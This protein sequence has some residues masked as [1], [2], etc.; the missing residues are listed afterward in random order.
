M[1]MVCMAPTHDEAV[2]ASLEGLHYFRNALRRQPDGSVPNLA[3]AEVT[4][5]MIRHG[6]L[7]GFAPPV[8]GTPDEAYELLAPLMTMPGVTHLPLSFRHAG[9]GPRSPAVDGP[10]PPR[11]CFRPCGRSK[12]QGIPAA[13]M[14][15]YTDSEGHAARTAATARSLPILPACFY[16][17]HE[18]SA[19]RSTFVTAPGYIQHN[20]GIPDGRGA[21]ATM[22]PGPD[23]LRSRFPRR[24]QAAARW[25]IQ[26]SSSCARLPR[27]RPRGGAVMERWPTERSSNTRTSSSRSPE[28][29]CN[30]HPLLL[31]GRC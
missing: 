24:P 27:G 10:V 18:T 28:T 31:S 14:I 22:G 30:D 13:A 26:A 1:Q 6:D 12:K 15:S 20:P 9:I 2:E 23:V 29:A 17:E 11:K 5:E 7:G 21:R 19:P 16:V 3:T 4:R 25:R 8:V